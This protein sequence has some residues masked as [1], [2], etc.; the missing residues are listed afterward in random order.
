[1]KSKK[2]FFDFEKNDENKNFDDDKLNVDE[3]NL[4]D[5]MN[6][7]ENQIDSAKVF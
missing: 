4:F 6:K 5:D 3:N 7:S 2:S 1:M